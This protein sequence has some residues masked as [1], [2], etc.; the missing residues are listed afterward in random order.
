MITAYFPAYVFLNIE[1][2]MIDLPPSDL[3]C[4]KTSHS[5]FICQRVWELPRIFLAALSTQKHWAIV[6]GDS[7]KFFNNFHLLDAAFAHY[8]RIVRCDFKLIKD[9]ESKES[10]FRSY[11]CCRISFFP[12][13]T[14][15]MTVLKKSGIW[16]CIYSVLWHDTFTGET[17]YNMDLIKY[18]LVINITLI[19]GVGEEEEKI[20][21]TLTYKNGGK[22]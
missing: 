13:R 9:D 1:E 12:H 15:F 22:K 8:S 17:T 6:P 4:C 19:R 7:W 16:S 14:F 5:A 3:D 18:Y 2:C 10:G 20:N 21:N 11:C